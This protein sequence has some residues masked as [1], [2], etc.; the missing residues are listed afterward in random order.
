ML[1]VNT[2]VSSHYVDIGVLFLAPCAEW[3]CAES[4]RPQRCRRGSSTPGWQ[5]TSRP[6]RGLRTEPIWPCSAVGVLSI[7]RSRWRR[8]PPRW[9]RSGSLVR[10]PGIVMRPCAGGGRRCRRSFNTPCTPATLRATRSTASTGRW[11]CP[12]IPR[13][14]RCCRRMR[15]TPVWRWRHCSIRASR[16]SW[17]CWCEMASSSAKR[18]R[19]TSTTSAGGRHARR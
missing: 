14:Q 11:S 12:G 8:T 2:L 3:Q 19:S 17:R 7:T 18:S 16:R 5:A 1:T 10:R 9:Q 13:G 6:T 15:S 4:L